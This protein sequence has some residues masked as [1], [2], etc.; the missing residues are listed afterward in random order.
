MLM[1]GRAPHLW[2]AASAWCGLYDLNDWYDVTKVRNPHYAGMIVQCCGGAPGSSA[3][4][5][6]QYRI[7]SPSAWLSK[8]VD[9]PTDINTGIKDGHQGSV[10]NSQSLDAFNALA[11]Q[12]DR[13]DVADI[14]Y[15]T[16]NATI[17]ASLT[18]AVDD[19]VYARA[20]VL[21]RRISGNV[22]VSVFNGGHEILPEAAL[23]WLEL[24]HKSQP[25]NWDVKPDTSVDLNG[26]STKASK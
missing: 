1:A 26:I 15:I 20:P 16:K 5:D 22:R 14:E 13:L 7:R 25:A 12:A 10:P 8:D 2:A 17:P 21:F 9:L 24:Q 18:A 4:V 23:A 3:D 11:A 6:E 19:P